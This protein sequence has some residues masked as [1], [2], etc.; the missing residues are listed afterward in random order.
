MGFAGAGAADEDRV[1]L[2]VEEAAGETSTK[3]EA[4]V[5]ATIIFNNFFMAA[6]NLSEVDVSRFLHARFHAHLI[7]RLARRAGII[8]HAG[9]SLLAA[10]FAA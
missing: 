10:H 7:L 2:G 6:S 5:A 9:L 1:T 4:T 8:F 3:I